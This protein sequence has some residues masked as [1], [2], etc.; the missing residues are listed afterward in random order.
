MKDHTK[1]SIECLALSIVA[2]V[3]LDTRESAPEPTV[4]PHCAICGLPHLACED[5]RASL[6]LEGAGMRLHLCRECRMVA[7]AELRR[8]LMRDS[9]AE[10]P[11]AEDGT[12]RAITDPPARWT[13]PDPTT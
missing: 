1:K 8:E 10:P 2:L 7:A 5:L 6:T 12:P 3:G 9:G 13:D 4:E 11:P